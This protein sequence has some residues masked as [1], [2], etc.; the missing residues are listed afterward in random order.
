MSLDNYYSG[1]DSDRLMYRK[2]SLDDIPDWQEFFIENP[3]LKYL[4]ID[5][6]EDTL[7]MARRWVN[8]QLKRYETASFGHLAMIR[9]NDL[10]LIGC[11]G[12]KYIEVNDKKY[13]SLMCAIKPQYWKQ[14]FGTEGAQQLIKLIA[15]YRLADEILF[16]THEKNI[17]GQRTL[18]KLG[19]KHLGLR[20]EKNRIV[21]MYLMTL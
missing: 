10:K 13:L 15:K 6:S 3:N 11:I 7:F 21:H 9:K 4:N 12:C 20:N 16:T 18:E 14:G 8:T 5:I 1:F 17:G 19:L 2:L